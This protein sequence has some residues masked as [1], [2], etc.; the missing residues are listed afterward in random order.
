MILNAGIVL[1]CCTGGCEKK[2][3]S[4]NEELRLSTADIDR[5]KG[6]AETGDAEAA[7]K[8]WHHYTFAEG[9][10]SQGKKWK[11]V[12]DDLNAKSKEKPDH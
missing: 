12:Y 6:K 3:L 5:Y 10:L 7:K 11:A 4:A 2:P 1:T 8:L 9:D